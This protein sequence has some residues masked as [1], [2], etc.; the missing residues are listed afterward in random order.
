LKAK[1]KIS[2]PGDHN[3]EEDEEAP[4]REE[5][6]EDQGAPRE[7]QLSSRTDS[8]EIWVAA[9]LSWNSF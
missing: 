9:V 1:V 4:S 6:R 7:L 2:F 3:G 5:D 8:T